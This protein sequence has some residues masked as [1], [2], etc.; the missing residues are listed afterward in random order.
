MRNFRSLLSP[1]RHGSV[2]VTSDSVLPK[3]NLANTHRVQQVLLRSPSSPLSATL[4]RSTYVRQA[5]SR[6]A[7][8]KPSHSESGSPTPRDLPNEQSGG[9]LMLTLEN[10]TALRAR[11]TD[12]QGTFLCNEDAARAARSL[13]P[14]TCTT[15]SADRRPASVATGECSECCSLRRELDEPAEESVIKRQKI[16]RKE[17]KNREARGA[18]GSWVSVALLWAPLILCVVLLLLLAAA[19]LYTWRTSLL[20]GE[21]SLLCLNLTYEDVALCGY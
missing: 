17:P 6:L 13:R 2:V 5:I 9:A 3:P 11:E 21:F 19:F 1:S 8:R 15:A 4:P 20:R 18:P 10:V 16:R 14:E 12:T 7:E